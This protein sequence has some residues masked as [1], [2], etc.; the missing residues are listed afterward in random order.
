MVP[1]TFKI[2]CAYLEDFNK[3]KIIYSEIVREP[4]FYL[5]ENGE[6]FPK[7]QPF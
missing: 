7:Q 5:D 4:Q 3:P 6:F 1:I 2:A